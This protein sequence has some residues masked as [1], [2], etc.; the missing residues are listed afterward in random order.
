LEAAFCLY[1]VDSFGTSSRQ[2][3]KEDQTLETGLG[4]DCQFSSTIGFVR[5]ALF[6]D[7]TIGNQSV[8]RTNLPLRLQ[9]VPSYFSISIMMEILIS[10]G[11]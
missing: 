5:I 11:A 7:R 4:T 2:S 9:C 3:M 6:L 8:A 10:R 1:D